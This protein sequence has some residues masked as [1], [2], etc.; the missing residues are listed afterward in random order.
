MVITTTGIAFTLSSIGLIVC[1]FWFYKAFQKIREERPGGKI[2]VLMSALFLSIA[3]QHSILA[4]GGLF[5]ASNPEALYAILTIDYF[6][7]SIVSAFSVY[8]LFYIISPKLSPWPPTIL[9]LLIG[10]ILV[11][12]IIEVHPLP[13]INTENSID[14]NMPQSLD[15]L[16]YFLL[17]FNIG[18]IF[19]IFSK[20]FFNTET[21]YVKIVS[22][23]ISVLAFVGI[24][25]ISLLFTPLLSSPSQR[26]LFF[27][28]IMGGVGLIFIV[29]F[30]SISFIISHRSKHFR[31]EKID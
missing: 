24:I 8:M 23:V 9:T 13:F 21:R 25:N 26:N 4:F 19:I 17:L 27:D 31:Q 10:I 28:M 6:L 12:L 2:G 1:S 29:V 14:W 7:L 5:F 18:S 20:N 22:L 3:I 30:V 15:S 16:A 11:S